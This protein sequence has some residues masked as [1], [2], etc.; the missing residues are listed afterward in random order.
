VQRSRFCFQFADRNR[1]ELVEQT[2]TSTLALA[3]CEL[4]L[5]WPTSR[6]QQQS[7]KCRWKAERNKQVSIRFSAEK[8]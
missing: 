2:S 1:I 7:P 4:E 3:R 8:P 6:T 5:N